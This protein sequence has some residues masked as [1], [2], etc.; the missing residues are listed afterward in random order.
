MISEENILTSVC[1]TSMIPNCI[2]NTGPDTHRKV[3]LPPHTKEAS[4]AAG[5]DRASQTSTTD[6][7]V[8]SPTG[9]IYNTT[10][11]AQ[12]TSQKRRQKDC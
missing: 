2:V 8:P 11:A 3:Q 9:Y 4:L 1:K 5:R 7:G 6:H 12:G 10:P